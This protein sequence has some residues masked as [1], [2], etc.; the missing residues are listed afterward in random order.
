MLRVIEKCA[1]LCAL[2]CAAAVVAVA[3]AVDARQQAEDEWLAQPVDDATFRSYLEFFTYDADLPFD[4]E[5]GGVE[6]ADGISRERLSFASTAGQRVTALLVRSETAAA[7]GQPAAILTHGGGA[8][9]KD[10]RGTQ[11][12]ATLL[13]RAG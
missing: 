13:A 6:T 2:L 9:G 10:G 12:Y 7:A 11:A 4:V 8:Q 5:V 3:P 1:V